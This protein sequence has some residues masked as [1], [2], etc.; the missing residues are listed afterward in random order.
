MATPLQKQNLPPGYVC[1]IVFQILCT[2]H[3]GGNEA[4]VVPSHMWKA[5]RQMVEK[6]DEGGKKQ[7]GSRLVH[8]GKG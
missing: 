5:A 7:V 4:Y 3:S 1:A 6:R 2:H 8:G